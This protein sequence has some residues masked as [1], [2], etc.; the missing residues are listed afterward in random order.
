MAEVSTDHFGFTKLLVRDMEACAQFYTSVCGLV[1]LAR[2]DSEIGGRAISEIMYHPT[3]EGAATFVL[4]KFEDQAPPVSNEVIVGFQTADVDAF[5][6]RALQA[7]GKLVDPVKDLPE[8]GVRVGF[9]SDIE[10][11]LI[12]VVELLS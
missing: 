11:H 6:E 4:L 5:V 3:G 12:E 7:G 8:H 10:G 2:V 9:V 1:E